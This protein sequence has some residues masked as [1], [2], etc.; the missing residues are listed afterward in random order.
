MS[1]QTRAYIY[2]ANGLQGFLVEERIISLLKKAHANF[3]LKAVTR[4]QV[5]DLSELGRALQAE[6]T[7][8]KMLQLLS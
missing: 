5:V 1:H 8:P 3:V 7:H 2:N 4:F 6:Q